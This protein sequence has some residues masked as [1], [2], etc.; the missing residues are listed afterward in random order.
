M[1]TTRID[2]AIGN[3]S[4][5]PSKNRPEPPGPDQL[6]KLLRVTLPQKTR[7]FNTD[8][9]AL[10]PDK[11][12]AAL[13][14]QAKSFH[15]VEKFSQGDQLRF[16]K[17]NTPG[18]PMSP[19]EAAAWAMYQLLAPDYVPAKA[20]A[21][22][23]ENGTYIG[24]SSQLIARFVPAKQSK[25][26]DEHLKDP[27]VVK[28]NAIGLTASYI[29][30]EDDCHSG[31]IDTE[32]DRVDYDMS[33]WP[34]FG[35]FKVGNTLDKLIRSSSQ[36]K[37]RATPRDLNQFPDIEDAK[38]HYWP[39]KAQPYISEGVREKLSK[40]ADV[41]TNAFTTDEN[42]VYKK[43]NKIP[44][45]HYYKFRTC[46]K[47]LLISD[48][49]IDTVIKQ[50]MPEAFTYVD[51]SGKEKKVCDILRDHIIERRKI[52]RGVLTSMES[53]VDFLVD[54]GSRAMDE[55]RQEF[56]A[57]NEHIQESEARKWLKNPQRSASILINNIIEP[58]EVEETYDDIFEEARAQEDARAKL[59][60]TSTQRL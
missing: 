42:E 48:D 18:S 50:H 21:H 28:G 41:S 17:H 9:L 37:F 20:N 6:A 23:N 33:F 14:E 25:L 24:V 8:K 26:T 4:D 56:A 10:K 5:D 45:F 53:F 55:I 11:L 49:I 13:P 15:A 16:F 58:N 38:P 22:V 47:F 34:V 1:L 19:L 27:E 54:S 59:V 39:T 30:E 12:V 32:G 57:R 44:E 35:L 36:S 40:W 29:F 60:K 43:F 52:L 7:P 31:N 2:P 46:L 51:A 3:N